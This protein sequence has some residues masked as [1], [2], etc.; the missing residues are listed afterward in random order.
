M[1]VHTERRA[2]GGAQPRERVAA[3]DRTLAWHGTLAVLLL[4]SVALDQHIAGVGLRTLR[5]VAVHKA[6]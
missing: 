2:R 5:A 4:L 3:N 6:A 1:A